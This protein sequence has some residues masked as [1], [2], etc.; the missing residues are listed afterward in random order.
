M[1]RR[2]ERDAL[3]R[4]VRGRRQFCRCGSP[5]NSSIR[6]A[7]SLALSAGRADIVSCPRRLDSQTKSPSCVSRMIAI[8]RRMMATRMFGRVA[9]ANLDHL[10]GLALDVVA[11]AVERELRVDVADTPDLEDAA[12]A[13][14]LV[15]KVCGSLD[16]RFAATIR[17]RRSMSDSAG[18]A[19][20]VLPWPEL[21]VVSPRAR[22]RDSMYDARSVSCAGRGGAG[23][24]W[25]GSGGGAGGAGVD[26]A[27]MTGG[28]DG[29]R[30]GAGG[31]GRRAGAAASGRA[32]GGGDG[33]VGA[34]VAPSCGVARGASC[35]IRRPR[36]PSRSPTCG[37]FGRSADGSVSSASRWTSSDSAIAS[38][39][40]GIVTTSWRR[41]GSLYG[42]CIRRS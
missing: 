9:A 21:V 39:R 20:G 1:R 23:G 11:P 18:G 41:G 31:G 22:R 40:T 42:Y 24:G 12:A 8:I 5:K 6:K 4:D 10:L 15:P 32:C 2:H 30:E 29:G 26:G 28:R 16:P 25:G 36:L 7:S 38:H 19:F 13:A 17:L 14:R 33:G 37:S 35:A 34:V 3:A 27:A